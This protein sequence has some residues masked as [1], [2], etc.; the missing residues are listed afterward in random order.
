MNFLE[1]GIKGA[2][3]RFPDVDGIDFFDNSD[4][5]INC[6]GLIIKDKIANGAFGI[7]YNGEVNDNTCAIKIENFSDD[8]EEQTN[9]LVEL[10]ILQSLPH[11]RL[12]HFYGAG[13][14]TKNNENKVM[15]IMELCSNGALRECLEQTLGWN[16]KIRI[17]LDIAQ[18]ILFLHEQGIIHR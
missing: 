16:L 6:A 13:V 5:S 2:H 14:E 10:T 7:V 15:I 4:F 8:S 1:S 11:D 12:V 17:A 18:G 3:E 9:L